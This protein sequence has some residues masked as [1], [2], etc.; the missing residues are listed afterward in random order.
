MFQNEDKKIKVFK[1]PEWFYTELFE[2]V[3][4]LLET[5]PL[6]KI[7]PNLKLLLS[8]KMGKIETF[9]L[10]RYLLKEGVSEELKEQNYVDIFNEGIRG[11]VNYLFVRFKLENGLVNDD[12]LE[13][14]SADFL[15]E[16]IAIYFKLSFKDIL[17][18]KD[19]FFG[20]DKTMQQIELK[21]PKKDSKN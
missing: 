21:F 20:E 3:K 14:M 19:M 6:N 15:K 9:R 2:K 10:L 5:L 12:E 4:E 11:F 8:Q 16:E 7:S 13:G 18:N 17:S 1:M